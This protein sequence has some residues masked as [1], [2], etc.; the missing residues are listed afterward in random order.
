LSKPSRR[1]RARAAFAICLL[2]LS[3]SFGC[4]EQWSVD[5]FPQMKWQRAVQ[6][7]ERVAFQG[8]DAAFLPP[9]GSVPIHGTE[10]L[11]G[12]LDI[13]AADALVNPRDPA[14]F[15]SLVN[16]EANYRVYCLPCHG[17]TGL[18]DGPV[19]MTG[20]IMGPFAGVFPLI[21]TTTIRSDGYIYNTIRLGG[22]GAPGFRMPSYNRIPPMDRWDIVNYVRYLDAKGGKP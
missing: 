12:R 3:G 10:P 13:A 8:R 2:L 18:G 5:W 15:R 14:D 20:G 1:T 6:P 22:G 4:W 11:I 21:G 17:P 19:S 9:E 16:G 7:F